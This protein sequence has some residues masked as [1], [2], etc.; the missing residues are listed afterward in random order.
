MNDDIS[1][2]S[3]DDPRKARQDIY[4]AVVTADGQHALVKAPSGTKSREM[5]MLLPHF[6]NHDVNR[7]QNILLIHIHF[8][9][10][11]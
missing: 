7:D 6:T 4:Q 9:L 10:Y 1:L 11:F 8:H 3:W 5:F 2:I